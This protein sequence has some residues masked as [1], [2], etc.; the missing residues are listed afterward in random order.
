MHKRN[1][2]E[3]LNT[4]EASTHQNQRV[5]WRPNNR[6][7]MEETARDWFQ[8]SREYKTKD[9]I[10]HEMHLFEDYK[11]TRITETSDNG[12]KVMRKHED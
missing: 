9:V 5:W 8:Y 10:L 3:M 6:Q 2:Y 11:I 1:I 7:L 4:M 12:C